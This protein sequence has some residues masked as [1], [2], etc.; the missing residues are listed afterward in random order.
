QGSGLILR[1]RT[2][3]AA[4]AALALSGAI[5]AQPTPNATAPQ[6]AATPAQ[7]APADAAASRDARPDG[8]RSAENVVLADEMTA[9]LDAAIAKGLA[10][11]VSE[12]GEDGSFGSGR[13]GKNVAVTALACIALLADGNTP[14]R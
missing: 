13:F 6:P 3:A 9:E 5:A 12:Q 8:S 14:S 11:L 1:T 10:Y 2:C 4:L 7:A